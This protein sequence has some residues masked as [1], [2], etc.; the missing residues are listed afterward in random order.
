M[1]GGRAIEA[2][3]TENAKPGEGPVGIVEEL[4]IRAISIR[5]KFMHRHIFFPK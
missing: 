2:E 4:F 5:D 1:S 3:R